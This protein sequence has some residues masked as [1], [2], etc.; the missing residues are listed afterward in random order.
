[1]MKKLVVF[2]ICVLLLQACDGGKEYAYNQKT[3]DLILKTM[4]VVDERYQELQNGA[5]DGSNSDK[6]DYEARFKKAQRIASYGAEMK[7]LLEELQPSE[8]AQ[9]FH[10]Q[11]GEYMLIVK[12]QYGPLFVRYVEATDSLEKNKIREEINLKNILLTAQA[13]KS[14]QV[15][16]AYFKRVGLQATEE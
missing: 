10:E 12:E 4:N 8:E 16:Q 9:D 3:A 14:L 15:Q 7:A 13:D 5:F 6:F 11:V 1:M 2:S